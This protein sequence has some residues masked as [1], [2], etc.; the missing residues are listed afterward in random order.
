MKRLFY[1]IIFSFFIFNIAYLS[2]NHTK[3][4]SVKYDKYHSHELQKQKLYNIKLKNKILSKND[5]NLVVNTRNCGDGFCS[6]FEDYYTCPEDC[7]APECPDG[8]VADCDG[9]GEC[10]SEGWINDGLCDGEDQAFGANLCCYENDGGD[11]AESECVA[12]EDQGQITCWNGDCADSESDCPDVTCSDTDCSTIINSTYF[13]YTCPEIE[14]EYG[15]DCSICEAEGACPISCEDQGLVTCPTG[16]CAN[17]ES[18]CNT[19]ENPDQAVEGVNSSTGHDQYY[20]FTVPEGGFLTL[21]TAGANIDTYLYLYATCDDIINNSYI[22]YNDDWQSSQ[23]GECPDCTYSLESYIYVGVPA[24]DY[25]IRSYDIYNSANTPFEWTLAFEVGVEGCT[26]P[27]ANNYNPEANIDDGSCEFDEGVFFITCD[28]GSFQSEVSWDLVNAATAEI[29]ISGGA[30]YEGA[31][32]LESGSYYLHAF[33]SWGDGWNGVI[34]TIIDYQSNEVLTYTLDE[35]NEGTSEIFIVD[36]GDVTCDG[37]LND[38][39]TINILD[40][41]TLVNAIINSNDISCGDLNDDDEVNIL[42]VLILLN[43]ILE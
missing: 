15:Y 42:D 43:L 33:D 24:G 14:Q 10:W 29:V 18:E 11:C 13:D 3:Q 26:N 20:Q 28:Q 8:Q 35:G 37:D 2:P 6:L 34:W 5:D 27:T 25:I 7:S 22:A 32:A 30:P 4:H 31:V 23:Y 12:C 9:S 17:L 38:D 39:D 16:V 41:L 1:C 21:S 36:F 40:I 19:C